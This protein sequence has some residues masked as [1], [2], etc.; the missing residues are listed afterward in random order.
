[1][2]NIIRIFQ[3]IRYRAQS[4]LPR[5]YPSALCRLEDARSVA[6]TVDDGPSPATPR[7]LDRLDESGMRATFFLSGNAVERFPAQ[8]RAIRDRGH[9]LASHGFA[10]DGL[11]RKSRAEVEADLM[12]GLA[13]IERITGVRPVSYRPPYGRLH[14]LHRGLPA[15]LGCT[16]V[17]WSMMPGDFDP[18]LSL[19]LLL[20]RMNH[21]KGGDIIVLHDRA[22]TAGR[23]LACLER[24][25]DT[26]HGTGF[27]TI[28]L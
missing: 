2:T 6:V 11:L 20:A 1:M 21:V 7:L 8:A 16:L 28:T 13:V 15:A 24:L 26:V 3:N 27:R 10:H 4:V 5:L 9:A 14:P 25:G 17:L 18:R 23:A 19:P 22:D 12:R